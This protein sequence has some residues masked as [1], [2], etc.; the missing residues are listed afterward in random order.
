MSEHLFG[1]EPLLSGSRIGSRPT[2]LRRQPGLAMNFDLH[3]GFAGMVA[4]L[5]N[6]SG[7][8]NSVGLC[9]LRVF[10]SPSTTIFQVRD[11]MAALSEKLVKPAAIPNAYR[12]VV[13]TLHSSVSNLMTN[14]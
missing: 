8:Y 11:A 10:D 6:M 12:S 7:T 3:M 1:C 2:S 14:K 5:P 13:E 9:P 4:Y